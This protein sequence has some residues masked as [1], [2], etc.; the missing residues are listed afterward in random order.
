MERDGDGKREKETIPP[1]WPP[2]PQ[3]FATL[4]QKIQSIRTLRN[5]LRNRDKSDGNEIEKTREQRGKPEQE[6][7]ENETPLVWPSRAPILYLV[8]Y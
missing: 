1:S 6:R 8:G 7:E 5:T 4:P 2:R 3:P